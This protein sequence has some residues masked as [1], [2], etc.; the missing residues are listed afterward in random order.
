M[1]SPTRA[2]V[3]TPWFSRVGRL[4]LIFTFTLGLLTPLSAGYPEG[5]AL[6]LLTPLGAGD[7]EPVRLAVLSFRPKPEMLAR[8]QPLADYLNQAV[9]GHRF[10]LR[11]YYYAELEAAIAEGQ[12]D[13]VLT[14]PA[15][16]VLMTYR[17]GVS[18]P[19]ATLV[20]KVGGYPLDVFGGVIFTRANRDN[21]ATLADL[22]R[23]IL[24]TATMDSLGSYQMQALELA[25]A[26]IH[27]P[28]DARVIETQPPQDRVVQAVLTGQADAGFV[29]TGVIEAMV[30]EGKLDTAALKIL[31]PRTMASF[32]HQLSTRLYPEWAFVAMPTT[33]SALARQVAAALLALPHDGAVA[34]AC[35][36][37]G[38]TIPADY[39]PVDDLLRE[40]RLPPFDAAPKFSPRD[41]WER[42]HDPITLA[43]L[44]G[45]LILL[46]ITVRLW[47]TNRWLK[48]ER[49]RVKASMARLADSEAR[50]SAI[51]NAL[52]EGVY[53]T[54]AQ[55]RCSFINP[56]AR[57]MLGIDQDAVLGQDQHALFHHHRPDGQPY[58][59]TECPIHFTQRD[60]QVRRQEDWFFRRDGIGF[61][62][63]IITAPLFEDGEIVGA[64]TAF[65]E[66]TERKRTEQE[67]DHYRHRL[68]ELVLSRTADLAEAKNAAEA[69]NRAKSVFLANMSHE[70]RT[71]M[72]AII[73]LTH[74]LRRAEPAPEQADRLD[75]INEA[76]QHLLRILNDILDLSKIE[77]GRLTLEETEFSLA[78]VMEHMLSLV[79]ERATAKG[80]RLV[81]TIAADV[82]ARLRGDPLRLGLIL[83]NFVSNAIKFSE[84]GQITLCVRLETEDEQSVLLR[85]EVADQ[86]I[87]LTPEQQARLFQAFVQADD[88]TTRKY[89]GTGL[90]LVIAKR[91]ANLM[92]GEVGVESQAGVGSTFW[93]TARLGRVT[94]SP[95]SADT[96][97]AEPASA[98]RILAQR[99]RGARL[100]LVE[101]D[102]INQ[103]VAIDLLR[104]VG[105]TVDVADNGQIAVEKIRV[106]AY[107]LVLMDLQM[108]VMDGLAATEAI[109]RLPGAA[110][111]P[112]LAM[113][114]SAFDTDRQRCLDAGMNDYVRKPVEPSQLY[115]T[116]LRWLPVPVEEAPVEV[117]SAAATPVQAVPEQAALFMAGLEIEMGLKTVSGNWAR[118]ARLLDLFAREHG[119]DVA[120]LRAH[121][122]AGRRSDA[123]RLAHTLKGVAATVGAEA[124]C[125]NA[126]VLERALSDEAN[127]VDLEAG[128]INAIDAALTPL[129]AAIR[130]LEPAAVP[131]EA[132]DEARTRQM[133]AQLEALLMVDDTQVT[134]VWHKC[135]PLVTAA[136]GPVA[137]QI[138]TAIER[139]EY[140]TAL[141][142]L[143][144]TATTYRVA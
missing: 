103:E 90:G 119:G 117:A 19:L 4:L 38:F 144:A 121:L 100:L 135:A 106:G 93:L 61:P 84:R 109:R 43:A 139:F 132:V 96:V 50:Q 35:H 20:D 39:H 82:P 143:R 111:L 23:K 79:G 58:P 67:L 137:T 89:G 21:I 76:A 114:A 80:L 142:V 3:A 107:A 12:V 98:D 123:C 136:L 34:R 56:A 22:R 29:R 85:L 105:L 10:T 94:E 18:S 141:Q 59:A 47:R 53:G 78:R 71:P 131:H 72:N 140:D 14:Q 41:I 60:G 104:A 99:Y 115:A 44:I 7:P 118:Y 62:V 130:R 91:L 25:H 134:Q 138:G 26:G 52:G 36:I 68:E 129:L 45:G 8:W 66:I 63:E 92:G 69:A 17:D 97:D 33:D 57:S 112:I 5:I 6:G 73:G 2:T 55:G 101:D 13:F 70:I 122:A 27:L 31:N 77:A 127:G 1:I 81:S 125:R 46:L 133:L 28:Q 124:V 87:G 37:Q 75:K 102:P 128:I 51:L 126:L 108:P 11:T 42:Y 116:L 74:L 30:R 15:H 113:T 9:P 40:L 88:S 65:Q 95:A 86:G 49:R 54:D 120:T 32:P 16:Y 24:A 83:L 48:V 110:T 64:V